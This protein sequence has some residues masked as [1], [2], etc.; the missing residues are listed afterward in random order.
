MKKMILLISAS[1]LTVASFAYDPN[2]KVLKAFTQTFT[3]AE[4]VKWEEYSDYYSVSFHTSGTSSRI[5]YDKE[6][7][8][9][10]STR[11]Y[12]PNLLPLNILNKLMRENPKRELFGV[13]ELT[14]GDDMVYF[15]KLQDE[16]HWITLKID[17]YGNSQ[18]Y[19]KYKKG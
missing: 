18:V 8:I 19:E 11:Y 6:G 7:N 16:K 15:V 1:L 10:S 5:N 3:T 9:I 2:T 17:T 13:T 14:V 12:L 4:N